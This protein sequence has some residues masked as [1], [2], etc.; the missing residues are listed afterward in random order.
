MT[1]ERSPKTPLNEGYV[2]LNKGYVPTATPTSNPQ[3]GHQPSGSP[4]G[5]LGPPPTTGSGVQPPKK[6]G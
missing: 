1:T 2:P 5:P 4:N 3:S 6:S